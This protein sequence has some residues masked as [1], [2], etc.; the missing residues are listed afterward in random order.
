LLQLYLEENINCTIVTLTTKATYYRCPNEKY[1]VFSTQSL[2]TKAEI[3]HHV[4]TIASSFTHTQLHTGLKS[5]RPFSQQH[6]PQCF[7]KSHFKCRSNTVS[8]H[9]CLELA[10]DTHDSTTYAT[11]SVFNRTKIRANWKSQV[12]TNEVRN[13][14]SSH[15]S[16]SMIRHA[17]TLS[18]WK[19]S[20]S[21]RQWQMWTTA[22]LAS[23]QYHDNMH[24]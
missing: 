10:P 6:H 7:V 24:Q 12:R 19:T 4:F 2:S 11:Y 16:S 5:L 21:T 20:A 18:C 14:T 9:P 22:S 13:F 1:P 15:C 3:L 23:V 8:A 17:G